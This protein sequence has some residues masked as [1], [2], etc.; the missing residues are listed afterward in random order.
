[1]ERSVE[2]L[3]T[4]KLVAKGGTNVWLTPA[5]EFNVQAAH[6][7]A[8]DTS[9]LMDQ[10]IQVTWVISGAVGSGIQRLG[11]INGSLVRKQMLAAVGQR[12]LI[13]KFGGVFDEYGL[14]I[15]QFLL[16]EADIRRAKA[17]KEMVRHLLTETL[18]A[19]IIPVINAND[20]M[21]TYELRKLAVSADNDHMAYFVASDLVDAD[22]LVFLTDK[23]GAM[24]RHR[25]V[26]REVRSMA[27]RRRI[28]IF[29][30]SQRG[31]GGFRS[32]VG[33]TFRFGRNGRQSFIGDGIN[34]DLIG[35][36]NGDVG[37]RFSID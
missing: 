4:R 36:L 25:Q 13:E 1:M 37:T 21:N 3:N 9:K 2:Q 30:K 17:K 24:D 27:D 34:M 33:F 35:I 32:K 29:E 15:G 20:T 5:G 10:G 22:T 26:I 7:A 19:G 31:T 14:T 28:H 16:S 11:D 23:P 18:Q 6:A 8:R 12:I